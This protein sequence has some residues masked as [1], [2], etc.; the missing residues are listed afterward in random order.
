[1]QEYDPDRIVL[2]VACT[3]Y[4]AGSALVAGMLGNM[5][6]AAGVE[7][8]LTSGKAEPAFGWTFYALS[9][10]KSFVRRLAELPDIGIMHMKGATLDQKFAIW[11][12]RQ[13][14]ARVEGVRVELLSDLRSSRF[15]LF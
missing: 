11:L 5:A 9:V 2:Q 14:Q 1:L 15:G 3:D 10:D 4:E 12:N 8:R 7:P 13:L 6:K